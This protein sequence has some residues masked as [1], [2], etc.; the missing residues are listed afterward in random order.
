MQLALSKYFF[1]VVVRICP[2]FPWKNREIKP[3]I[4]IY[5]VVVRE[6]LHHESQSSTLSNIFKYS[7]S[8]FS[9]ATDKRYEKEMID[10]IVALSLEL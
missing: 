5:S 2:S 6:E 3:N 9:F 10:L 4:H 1:F 7:P 8:K